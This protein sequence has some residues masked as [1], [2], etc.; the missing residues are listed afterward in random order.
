MATLL[1]SKPSV[2]PLPCRGRAM[3]RC[4]CAELPFSEIAH[5][6]RHEGQTL[7]EMAKRTGCGQTCTACLPDLEEYLASHRR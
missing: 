5:R 1:E 7:A 6:M 2:E 3:T 4:E